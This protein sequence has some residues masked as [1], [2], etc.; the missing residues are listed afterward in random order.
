MLYIDQYLPISLLQAPVNH[1]S[2]LCLSQFGG[3]IKIYVYFYSIPSGIY[4]AI[5]PEPH[6]SILLFF[7]F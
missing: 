1:H 4:F 3:V 6:Y 7:M 2:S 5:F